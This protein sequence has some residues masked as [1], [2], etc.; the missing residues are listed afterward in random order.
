MEKLGEAF[1]AL[2]IMV[3]LGG[4][5]FIFMF[6]MWSVEHKKQGELHHPQLIKYLRTWLISVSVLVLIS[7]IIGYFQS[8]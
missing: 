8:K 5:F 3:T 4:G 2:F 6:A 7:I 1:G